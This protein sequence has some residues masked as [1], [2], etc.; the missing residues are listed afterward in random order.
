MYLRCSELA[1]KWV[2]A[3]PKT[4]F[5]PMERATPGGGVA[6]HAFTRARRVRPTTPCAPQSTTPRRPLLRYTVCSDVGP[7]LGRAEVPDS[8]Q[9]LESS[10]GARAW[11]NEIDPYAA[12]WL[13]NLIRAGLIAPG[14]VD[15][16][17]I[18]DVRPAD[19]KGYTQCHFFA[20]VGGWSYAL[21]LAGWPDDLPVWTGSCP[22]QPFSVAG[23]GL[24]TDDS[25][26]LW[27]EWARLLR[28]G[29][30]AT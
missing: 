16:R 4:A 8:L 5:S 28:E 11:Y 20:G 10:S 19:L 17:S 18:A 14:D 13:R 22:C 27:P 30:P 6:F 9:K 29:R 2:L 1:T 25:R 15:E 21:R 23:K 12:D 7:K 26:H 24:G 3:L